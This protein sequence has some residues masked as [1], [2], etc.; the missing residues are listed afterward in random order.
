LTYDNP[1]GGIFIYEVEANVT[2]LIVPKEHAP[3][4]EESQDQ[5]LTRRAYTVQV[6]A[7]GDSGNLGGA[8]MAITV[9]CYPFTLPTSTTTM[10]P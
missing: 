5:C 6:I 4:L 1:I 3:R 8:Q 9:D 10:S 2:Q 7:F